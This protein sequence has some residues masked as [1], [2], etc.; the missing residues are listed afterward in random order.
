MSLRYAYNTNGAANHRLDDALRLI[1][2][3]GY[4]GVALTLDHHHL[5][6]FAP[7]WARE[8]ERVAR[9]LQEL[10]LGS[11][12]ET[13]A[14]YLLDPREKHEPTL[15]TAA[16][17]GRARRVAFLCRALDIAAMLGSET[18]SFWA[19]VP[20]PGVDAQAAHGWLD[21]GLARVLDYA[22]GCGVDAS[23]EPE[24]GML[25]ETVADYERLAE[26]HPRLRLALDTGHCLVTQDIAPDLAV[27]AYVDRI[28]TVAI[29]D[30]RRGDH[31]HLPF[32]EGDMDIPAVLRALEDI[33]YARLV[34]V[35][36]S[37]ESPRAHAA[38]PESIAYLRSIGA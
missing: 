11:V 15:V 7:N 34:C 36:M 37:R 13:G 38:I 10:R 33:G 1:A 29:E 28:G 32:G 35:E 8:A 9:V 23:F 5:D 21:E 22:E 4:D 14:R 12:I 31:T 20:K 6:P 25:I 2:D 24:P 19:G 3:C 27:H 26:R 30:M 17:D 16:A 18:M